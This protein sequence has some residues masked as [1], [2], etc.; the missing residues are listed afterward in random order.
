[1]KGEEDGYIYDSNNR[2]VEV[3]KKSI[4]GYGDTGMMYLCGDLA[5]AVSKELSNALDHYFWEDIIYNLIDNYEIYITKIP[6][7]IYEIDSVEDIL[8][9]NLMNKED[10]LKLANDDSNAINELNSIFRKI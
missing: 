4:N 8:F 9:Y 5:N 2:V 7:I 1:M 6:N 10:I 3:I